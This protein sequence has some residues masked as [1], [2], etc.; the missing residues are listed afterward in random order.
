MEAWIVFLGMQEAIYFIVN[1]EEIQLVS[2][3]MIDAIFIL[4]F[5]IALKE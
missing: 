1:H 5:Y 2:W 3:R 4:S